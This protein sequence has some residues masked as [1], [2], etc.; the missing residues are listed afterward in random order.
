MLPYLLNLIYLAVWLAL[1]PWL[2]WQAWF[3]KKP[4]RGLKA[5]WLGRVGPLAHISDN[6]TKSVVWFHGVSV[7]EIHLL[8][9]V[10]ARFREHFPYWQC[11]ISTTTN[12][13]HDE[14]CKHFPD[15]PVIYWPFDFTWAV[16]AALRTIKPK[17]VV[18]SEG[19]IWPNFVRAARDQGV[20]IALINGRTSPRSARRFQK[21]R[22]LVADAFARLDWIGAQNDEYRRHYAMLGAGNVVATGNIKYDGVSSERRNSRTEAM[23]S[24]LGIS[25]NALVWVCGSTQHPEES[26]ALEIFRRARQKHPALRLIVVPRH[27]ER[28]DEVARLL[29]NNGLPFV[30]RS[31]LASTPPTADAIILGDTMGELSAIWGL[32]DIAFVGGSLDGKRGGQN[33]IEPSAYGAAVLF[34]P[35]TWN[36][37]QTV[38][39]LLARDAAIQVQDAASLEA[40]V[41]R[42]LEDAALRQ[43]LGDAAREFVLSQ[44]GATERTLDALAA[45]MNIHDAKSIAA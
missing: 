45:L 15:L 18:L 25:P 29:E 11:V 22:W 7:G 28:F 6:E 31:A 30:R 1:A 26:I 34:G 14:A 8:R 36:F 44:Q 27:P 17:L 43:R 16:N 19:E 21:F 24:L 35:D 33:M 4:L 38:I 2:C 37:K 13:G 12:T 39:D 40:A 10:V 5:K 41:L 20:K 32:A 23:R 9:Q 3:R 42:L